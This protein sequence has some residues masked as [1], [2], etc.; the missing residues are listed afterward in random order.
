[1]V[2]LDLLFQASDLPGIMEAAADGFSFLFTGIEG[3]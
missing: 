2:V 1:M 3:M